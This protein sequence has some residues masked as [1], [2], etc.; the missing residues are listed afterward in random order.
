MSER[1][2]F[3]QPFSDMEHVDLMRIAAVTMWYHSVD[4]AGL[5][6]VGKPRASLAK[7]LAPIEDYPR[8]AWR[9]SGQ[10]ADRADHRVHN[11]GPNRGRGLDCGERVVNGRLRGWCMDGFT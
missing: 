9:V 10:V 11:H 3:V 6:P 4:R 8:Y 1:W 7:L 5:Q 2:G